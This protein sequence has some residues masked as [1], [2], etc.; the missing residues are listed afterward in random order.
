MF[1]FGG[2]YDPIKGK[3]IK[4]AVAVSASQVG[5]TIMSISSVAIAVV[6]TVAIRSAILA[7][8]SPPLLATG[9]IMP[10]IGFTFGYIISSIV[11]LS[12]A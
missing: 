6:A 4:T 2:G 7:V 9:A 1:F 12:Q 3:K 5:L 8:M 10:F 11:R